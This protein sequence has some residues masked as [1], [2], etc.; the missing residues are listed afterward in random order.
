MYRYCVER[1]DCG[2]YEGLR[3]NEDRHWNRDKRG[4]VQS[5]AGVRWNHT[6]VVRPP[7]TKV[8]QILL[9]TIRVGGL[10]FAELFR[11][12]KCFSKASGPISFATYM[13]MCLAHPTEGYYMTSK[14]PVFGTEGDFITS[15]EISQIF[16]EVGE[17]LI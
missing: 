11:A 16:G 2:L 9:D 5:I 3:N 12:T 8:E 10:R 13:Q 1:N 14:N 6:S 7:A 17:H 4:C 15:P